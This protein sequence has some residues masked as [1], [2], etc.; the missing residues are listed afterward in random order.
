[1]L[2]WYHPKWRRWRHMQANFLFCFSIIKV[3]GLW[4]GVGRSTTE[5]RA[6]HARNLVSVMSR[7]TPSP[8]WYVGIDRL[9]LCHVNCTWKE[10]ETIDLFPLDAGMARD[11]FFLQLISIKILSLNVMFVF[12]E[13]TMELTLCPSMPN[14]PLN[15]QSEESQSDFTIIQCLRFI[16]PIMTSYVR[17]RRSRLND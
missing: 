7:I 13:Q 14:P 2:F 17:S 4:W 10:E 15:S 16:Y 8:D 1:M 3:P 5:F 12:Q 9:N 6:D 11:T